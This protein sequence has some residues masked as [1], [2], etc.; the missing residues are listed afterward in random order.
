MNEIDYKKVVWK[1]KSRRDIKRLKEFGFVKGWKCYY[2]QNGHI[3]VAVVLCGRV[4][5]FDNS[6]FSYE[7]LELSACESSGY[8]YD[9]IAAEIVEPEVT[10]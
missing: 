3:E 6:N 5:F 1:L 4:R 7:W 9:L 2:R 8:I 10:K